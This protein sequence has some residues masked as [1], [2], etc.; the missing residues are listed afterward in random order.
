MPWIA[1]VIACVVGVAA[2]NVSMKVAGDH[3]NPFVFTVGLTAI[4][5]VGHIVCLLLYKFHLGES[6][7][8]QV[9]R[10][11]VYMAIIAGVAVVAIDLCMFFAIKTGGVVATNLLFTVG[12]MLLTALAGFLIFKEPL[13][14]MKI[15]GLCLGV[16]SIA[17]ITKG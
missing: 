8:F 9:D 4:A 6:V 12:A 5:F 2:Y 3:I 17:M 15:A 7:T 16:I 1:Y 14:A 13:S 11:G 10:T